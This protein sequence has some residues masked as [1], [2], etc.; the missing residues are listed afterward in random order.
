M[1]LTET[2]YPPPDS[3]IDSSSSPVFLIFY[4]NVE[5]GSMWC[6]HCRD[7]QGVVKAAF[8]GGSKPRGV[9]TYVGNY[10]QWKTPSHPA[11]GKYG[12][13]SVPTIIKFQNG[14]ETG[15][16]TKADILDSGK[17]EAFLGV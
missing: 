9:I 4:S 6:P 1:P 10:T 12:V 7:V 11:R 3:A 16:A 2:T 15:R 13:K 14:K 17:F 5:G 8:T